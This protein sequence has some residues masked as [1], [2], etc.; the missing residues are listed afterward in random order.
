MYRQQIDEVL[1][2]FRKA[3][4]GEIEEFN[5]EN[6]GNALASFME[7]SEGA[8]FKL[9]DQYEQLD[10]DYGRVVNGLGISHT[11]AA[12]LKRSN[13]DLQSRVCTSLYLI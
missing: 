10:H 3:L 5:P 7:Q 4:T 13:V 8:R 6:A 12:E 11:E 2:L 9:V 1:S